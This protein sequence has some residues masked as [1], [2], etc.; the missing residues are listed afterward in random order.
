M[1][2][3]FQPHIFLLAACFSAA[4]AGEWTPA[5]RE[6]ARYEH[7]WKS[8]PFVAKAEAVP[9]ADSTRFAVTGFARVGEDEVIFLLDRKSLNRF[10]IAQ[11]APKNGVELIS[12]QNAG[13]IKRLTAKIR[14]N[15]EVAT[16]GF[17]A[18]PAPAPPP[19]PVQSSAAD[20]PEVTIA[21][22]SA[23]PKPARNIQRKT[24][25]VQ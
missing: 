8:A 13:D 21:D 3:V 20:P 15:G 7:I 6:I 22:K 11:S 5:A 17:D 10:S 24:I 9:E 16:I 12:V 25:R 23:A 4:T 19:R 18:S 1:N 2:C 14:S